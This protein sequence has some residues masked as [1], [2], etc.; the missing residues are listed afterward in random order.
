MENTIQAISRMFFRAII[1]SMSIM[2]Y[3]PKAIW[4]IPLGILIGLCSE[5]KYLT[6]KSN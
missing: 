5:A 1:I 2:I 6:G 4:A 3:N